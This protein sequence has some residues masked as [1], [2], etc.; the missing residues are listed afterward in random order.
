MILLE[1]EL[2][3]ELEEF[4]DPFRFPTRVCPGACDMRLYASDTGCVR[5]ADAAVQPTQ[6]ATV[7]TGQMGA[8]TGT[9]TG[10]G[11]G[12]GTGTGTGP[13]SRNW[14]LSRRETSCLGL[15]YV[16]LPAMRAPTCCVPDA[17]WV[18]RLAE[19][20]TCSRALSFRAAWRPYPLLPDTLPYPPVFS[21][22]GEY[23]LQLGGE[24]RRLWCRTDLSSPFCP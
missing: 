22:D 20:P 8:V 10:T 12:P 3:L 21:L 16:E 5:F 9:G 6:H 19:H 13:V 2:E 17:H 23:G 7:D 15:S 11:T 14:M 4:V 24:D 1:L 18:H